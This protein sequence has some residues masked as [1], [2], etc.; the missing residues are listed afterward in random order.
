M[1]P[2]GKKI[3]KEADSAFEALNRAI[4]KNYEGDTVEEWKEVFGKSFNINEIE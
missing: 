4:S 1:N 3:T 2:S